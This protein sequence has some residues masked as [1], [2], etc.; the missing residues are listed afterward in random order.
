M[1]GPIRFP[2]DAYKVCSPAGIHALKSVSTSI[3]CVSRNASLNPVDH[4]SSTEIRI[5]DWDVGQM[6]VI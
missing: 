1:T 6:V 3:C 2:D 4:S 5:L